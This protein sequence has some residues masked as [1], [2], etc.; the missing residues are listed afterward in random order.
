MS[1]TWRLKQGI[2]WGQG[3]FKTNL[4]N[5]TLSHLKT[6][7]QNVHIY[8]KINYKNTLVVYRV[9]WFIVLLYCDVEWELL[10][11]KGW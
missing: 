2:T 6:N 7:Q 8:F 9:N 3:K 4:A 10:L 5:T 11:G 1:I